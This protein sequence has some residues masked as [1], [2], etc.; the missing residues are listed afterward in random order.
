MKKIY[1]FLG[2]VFI[3][4]SCWFNPNNDIWQYEPEYLTV[5]RIDFGN[6]VDSIDIHLF[7]DREHYQKLKS[8]KYSVQRD[9]PW[10]DFSTVTNGFLNKDEDAVLTVTVNRSELNEGVNNA[11]IIATIDNHDYYIDVNATGVANLVLSANNIDFGTSSIKKT[12]TAYS[13]I[14]NSRYFTISTSDTWITVEPIRF[15]LTENKTGENENKQTIV[16]NCYKASLEEGKH[17]GIITITSDGGTY[18]KDITITTVVPQQAPNTYTVDDFTFSINKAPYRSSTNVNIELKIK[19]NSTIYR[20]LEF[21]YLDS[22]AT[23]D[24]GKR[25]SVSKYG[26]IYIMPDEEKITDVTLLNVP[27]TVHNMKRIELDFGLTSKII[28][29]NITF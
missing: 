5:N 1:I 13:T 10:I 17:N 14:G 4:S 3:V 8:V 9:Q 7:N 22:K 25:Y 12:F 2:I 6:D 27:D 16:I 24:N 18:K 26:D 19:N 11:K 20:M 21:N 29:E 28:F 23:D 15:M